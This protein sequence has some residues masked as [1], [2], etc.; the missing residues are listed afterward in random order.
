MKK[1]IKLFLISLTACSCGVYSSLPEPSSISPELME[2][3]SD[4]II[5]KLKK[6]T[7]QDYI[8]KNLNTTN[9]KIISKE[10][11]LYKIK[12]NPSALEDK[13]KIYNNCE[14]IE[15]AEPNYIIHLPEDKE[16]PV[17]SEQWQTVGS[18]QPFR[19]TAESST[20]TPNDP[21]Y[22]QQWYMKSAS[23]D[24]AW[25]LTQGNKNIT[26]AV[27][28]SGVDPNHPDLKE[29]L[30]P[31]KDVWQEEQGNDIYTTS[32]KTYN[33]NGKDGN[34]HG[35]HVTGIIA[36]KMDNNQGTAGV[37][38]GG[39]TILPIK[40]TDFRGDTDASTL[41]KAILYAVTSR[42][43]ILNVSIGGPESEGSKALQDSIKSA[44]DNGIPVISATGNESDR[45]NKRIEEVAVPAAYV[46]VIAV[47]ANT[48]FNKVANYS[49]GGPS[50]L[51]TAPGGGSD[52]PGEGAKILST[53]P[54]YPTYSPKKGPYDYMAGT[55]MACPVVT[56]I[57]ALMLS[58]EPNLK[59]A[60]IKIRL[61]STADDIDIKGRD[62]S[63]GYGIID[64][65]KALTY[66]T[67]DGKY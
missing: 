50:T 56:G 31:L 51:L 3:K 45:A 18:W 48:Q 10:R 40:A 47:A 21:L 55:S 33:Y 25:T 30:L 28:D 64:A 44:I 54:T 57:V 52:I 14:N 27:V 63:T 19:I 66:R 60:Q 16:I 15:F 34:G 8:A 17:V 5:L 13:I 23:V 38:G 62:E 37:S 29:S 53:W 20:Y 46:N 49:N 12:V 32:T 39:V 41:T 24:K 7:S 65:Y 11:D 2:Y 36:A 35:T 26:I 6:G 61:I 58:L 9:Y 22:G 59:P 67:H 43:N 4:E 42:V 1:F